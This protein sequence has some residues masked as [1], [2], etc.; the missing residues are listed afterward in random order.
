[1]AEL[2]ERT[3]VSVSYLKTNS[4]SHTSPLSAFAELC[5]NSADAKSSVLKID[6]EVVGGE[7]VLIFYRMLRF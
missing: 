5:D 6:H 1:M 7:Q 2:G 4:T 3:T